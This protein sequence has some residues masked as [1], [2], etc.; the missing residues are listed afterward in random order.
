M[1]AD[2]ILD[3]IEPLKSEKRIIL[4]D[5]QRMIRK[6]ELAVHGWAEKNKFV[7]LFCTG[8][9]YM[10]DKF[11]KIRDD[12]KVKMILVDRSREKAEYRLF[13]PDIESITK[14][15]CRIKLTLLDF[16]CE[17]TGDIWPPMVN[18]RI[19]S[20]IIIENLEGILKS[21]NAFRE[22]H[23]SG[24]TDEQLYQV[25]IGGVLGIKPFKR[26]TP[27]EVRK[28][29]I[30]Q[31]KKIEEL[32]NLL[33]EE[34]LESLFRAIKNA[35]KPFNHLLDRDPE[36]VISSFTLAAILHRH[37]LDYKLLIGNINPTLYEYKDISPDFLNQAMA[38]Q[39]KSDPDRVIADVQ[40]VEKYLM[41]NPE[42]LKFLL[43]DRLKIDR[44]FNALK[45]LKAEKL[46]P[47]IRSMSLIS[48]L[49][50][51]LEKQTGSNAKSVIEFIDEEE[52]SGN[53]PPVLRRPTEE[54]QV[55]KETYKKTV[56][57]MSLF[58]R[59]KRYAQTL[60]VAKPSSIKFEA[61][62][63]IWNENRMNRLEYYLS[64]LDRLLRVGNMLPIPRKSFWDELGKRWDKAR[65]RFKYL[66]NQANDYKDFIDGKFQ[67]Y[68]LANY[69][70]FIR[71]KDSPMI[72]TH[73]FLSRVFKPNWDPKSEKKA[74]IM[75]FDGLRIDAWEEFLK[76]VFEER[77]EVI[78]SY[79]GSAILPTET[80]LSRKAISAGELPIQFFRRTT[81][82]KRLLEEWLEKNLG[83][84]LKL[85][86]IQDD[87][88]KSSGMTARFSSDKVEL[89]IFN[90]TDK[91]LHGNEQELALMYDTVVRK[92][93]REDVRSVLRE[94]PDNAVIF[95]TSDHGFTEISNKH[96][97]IS[98]RHTTDR[99]DV[100]FRCARI[101]VP[102]T[103]RESTKVMTFDATK[104]GIPTQVNSYGKSY[105]F[106]NVIF[107]KPGYS[108]RR[109]G[110]GGHKDKYSHGG[111]SMGECLIPMIV[112]GKKEDI[113]KVIR[114][115]KI[116][117]RGA[118]EEGKEIEIVVLVEAV[119]AIKEDIPITL[120][121]NQENVRPIKEIFSG[122]SQEYTIR[123]KP[124]VDVSD[125]TDSKSGISHKSVTVVGTY[126]YKD[127]TIRTSASTDVLIRI[128][129]TR[130]RRR[131]DSK[132]DM[133]M[134]MV[135]KGL[136]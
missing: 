116:E 46:S 87:D 92:M 132:L 90:F 41:E 56:E 22:I 120:E 52:S 31:H 32:K 70:N 94:L 23:S 65:D 130:I 60:R 72:F 58:S 111:L 73:Q 115:T 15:K 128:E 17:K 124:R 45:V 100:K 67:E 8:N 16:L 122:K 29:C 13:Y 83:L 129:T 101:K 136:R 64:E 7:V 36:D 47:L 61:F 20:G 97:T 71:S 55:L 39:M 110:V 98:H 133:I 84:S 10:R 14:D 27:T 54:W 59:L 89:I 53:P 62:D 76:Q 86:T 81:N 80:Q 44:E 131:L 38:D 40:I 12:K 123:W 103:G 77:F 42:S 104:M 106:S 112:L 21:H 114:I 78:K 9:L 1:I 48:L 74:F 18:D 105:T 117:E 50:H 99:S 51:L 93:I 63:K 88:T 82:E 26:L 135:P 79:P 43:H 96:I 30:E 24:F 11:E 37:D 121:L 4:K 3:K 33:P 134:G 34:A 113:E 5:P 2:W 75:I 19:I 6:G 107:P 91:M 109:P 108:F 125:I 28:V 119:K 57:I 68:Y 118:F 25:I 69:S 127:K 95:I 126:Q 66:Y 102:L 35:P 49:L 85:D